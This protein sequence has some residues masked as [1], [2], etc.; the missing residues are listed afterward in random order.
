LVERGLATEA[1]RLGEKRQ[2]SKEVKMGIRKKERVH[3]EATEGPQSAR[4]KER[5]G[6]R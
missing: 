1:Q 2:R 3:T 4:R 6:E 5:W